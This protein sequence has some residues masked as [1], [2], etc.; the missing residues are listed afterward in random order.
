MTR[1]RY[2]VEIGDIKFFVLSSWPELAGAEK[3]VCSFSSPIKLRRAGAKNYKS[4]F[5]LEQI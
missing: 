3:M 2:F 4:L 5:L 1:E